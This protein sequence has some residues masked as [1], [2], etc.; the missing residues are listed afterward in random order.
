VCKLHKAIYGLKQAP[1]AWFNRFSSFLLDIGFKASLVD[2]S[3]FMFHNG[4]THLFMLIYV[5]DII[6]TGTYPAAVQSVI[7]KL[8]QEFPVKDL[9]P[10]NFFLGIQ[11][12]RTNQ[13][14][15]IS[16]LLH[17]VKMLGAKPSK[18]PCL[19]G[20]KLSKFDGELLKDLTTYRHIV[21]ALQYYTLTRP[22]VA[23]S[24]NQLCQHIHA[25]TSSH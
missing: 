12:Q 24:V 18:S 15:Y 23:F 11:V 14:K 6:I 5:D 16:D 4:R 3:L 20:S 8:Q 7:L 25:P 21:G 13:A 17:R 19:A 9:G 1:R 22:D 10:L 2:S